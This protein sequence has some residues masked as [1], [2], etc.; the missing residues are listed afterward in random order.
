[1]A[2]KEGSSRPVSD[3]AL[4]ATFA[5]LLAVCSVSAALPIGINGVP[6]TLQTFGVLMCGAVLGSKRG[7]LAVLLYLAIGIAGLPVFAAGA[8]GLAPFASPTAGYLL[9][10][11]FAAALIG[12]FVPRYAQRAPERA[13]GPGAMKLGNRRFSAVAAICAGGLLA[14][15]LIFV[16]GAGG[17]LVYAD[18]SLTGALAAAALYIPGDL[19]KLAAVITLASSVHRAF[20]ALANNATP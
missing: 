12:I 15:A 9:A 2:V 17:I 20:P 6:I 13:I 14:E 10:F 1:M 7:F 18:M 5:A 3:V 19:I 11:P 16:M 4:V 8:A